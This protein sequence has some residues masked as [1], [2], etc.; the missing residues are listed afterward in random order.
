MRSHLPRRTS[1]DVL[2][3]P[4]CLLSIVGG[5][6]LTR[7][8]QLDKDPVSPLP[9]GVVGGKVTRQMAHVS[10]ISFGILRVQAA[11][12]VAPTHQRLR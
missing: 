1:R 2:Q 10:W 6:R 8:N 9:A 12:S 3:A 7:S 11:S 4:L 5:L